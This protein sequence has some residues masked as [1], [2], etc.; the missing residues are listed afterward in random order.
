MKHINLLLYTRP[1][2]LYIYSERVLPNSCL[3]GSIYWLWFLPRF[4][5]ALLFFPDI[6]RHW[7]PNE[8]ILC[9]VKV[10]PWHKL[11]TFS[12]GSPT[13]LE[14][15]R[16]PLPQTSRSHPAK[17]IDEWRLRTVP[18][19]TT[20]WHG[21][22]LKIVRWQSAKFDFAPFTLGSQCRRGSP[23][24]SLTAGQRLKCWERNK[25]TSSMNCMSLYIH[26][27]CKNAQ[28]IQNHKVNNMAFKISPFWHTGITTKLQRKARR[29]WDI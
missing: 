4:Y 27:S 20:A 14:S 19:Q 16:Q 6:W 7:Q 12:L 9:S 10:D 21:E 24:P 1:S 25:K 22:E 8:T 26:I 2:Y 17:Q 23:A 3:R 29:Q 11:V 15:P 5:S 13:P 18:I 28:V